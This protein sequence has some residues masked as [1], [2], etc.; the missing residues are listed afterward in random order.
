MGRKKQEEEQ[1]NPEYGKSVS[2]CVFLRRIRFNATGHWFIL[3]RCSN[4]ES[5]WDR[6]LIEVGM[7]MQF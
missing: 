5:M 6:K 2:K 4:I 1:N 7:V 3:S